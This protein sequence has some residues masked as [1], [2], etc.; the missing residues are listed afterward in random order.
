MCGI[1]GI[2]TENKNSNQKNRVLINSMIEALYH[3][4]PDYKGTWYNEKEGIFLGHSRLSIIDLSEKAHQPMIGG[5]GNTC[6]VYNGEV[7][8]YIE[9]RNQLKAEGVI[10]RTNSDT[11]V[12]LALYN[13][14]GL[15]FVKYLRGMFALAIWDNIKKILILARDRVGKKPLY[16]ITF[17]NNLYFASETKAIKKVIPRHLLEIDRKAL[18]EYLSFGFISGE[19]TI[20]KNIRELPPSSLL[21][22]SSPSNF[23]IQKYWQPEWLPKTKI[24]FSQAVEEASNILVDAVRIRLRA[25]VPVGIFLSGGIDSSLVTAIAA[26]VNQN[27]CITFSVGFEDNLFDE[28]PLARL[29]AEQYK[30]QHHEILI[31][32]DI[33]VILPRIVQSYDEPFADASAIPSYYI[34]EYASR[35]VKVILNGDGGDEL[36]AGYRRHIATAILERLN[37]AY[38]GFI[39]ER[40]GNNLLKLM[41]LPKSYRTKYAFLYRFLRALANTDVQRYRIFFD[42]GFESAEKIQLYKFVFSIDYGLVEMK[43]ILNEINKLDE[44]DQIIALDFLWGLPYD[45]LVKMDIATMAHGL[46]ARSPFL[47]QELV[48]WA[49]KLP[50]SVKLPGISTKPILREIAKR[51]LPNEIVKA[52]KRGFEIPLYKWLTTDLKDFCR[53]IILSSNNLLQDLFNKRYLESLLNGKRNIE[54]HRWSMM[55][56]ILLMLGLWDIYCYKS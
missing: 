4:G 3:R 14:Y 6:I 12:V 21:V 16:Y 22:A 41:P 48:Q 51:Y 9:I 30:T 26:K 10:F 52:P 15:E 36:F 46:E 50:S 49:N 43:K 19:K 53:D 8:N 24:N 47:D 55:V 25:D 34:S 33:K 7:Y 56:W 37:R 54:P 23:K 27:Q 18:D 44:L 31:K 29:V 45:L 42:E 20:Y 32:P 11:E 17:E 1:A 5:Q 13:K 40:L 2:W 28:R 38:I 35:Y 39:L